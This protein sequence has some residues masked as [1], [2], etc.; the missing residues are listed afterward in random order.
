MY[1]GDKEDNTAKT[2]QYAMYYSSSEHIDAKMGVVDEA[3]LFLGCHLI[4]DKCLGQ[5]SYDQRNH[6]N[7][8]FVDLLLVATSNIRKHTE[9]LVDY[10]LKYNK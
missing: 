9:L 6:Y 3:N 7:A 8:K 1:I 10:N 2:S 4:N 5:E